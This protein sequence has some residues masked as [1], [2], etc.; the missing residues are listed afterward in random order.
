V[1]LQAFDHITWNSDIAVEEAEVRF[2][3]QHTRIVQRAAIV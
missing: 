1:L 2:R 3:L